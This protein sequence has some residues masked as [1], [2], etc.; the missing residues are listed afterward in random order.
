MWRLAQVAHDLQELSFVLP[1]TV[2]VRAA[3]VAGCLSEARGK[4]PGVPCDHTHGCLWLACLM[5]MLHQQLARF[6]PL[7][8]ELWRSAR[9]VTMTLVRER[10]D[11]EAQAKK[12]PPLS[13][14]V[15]LTR[16]LATQ[17]EQQVHGFG[18]ARCR[19][20]WDDVIGTDTRVSVSG[21]RQR[22]SARA[23]APAPALG[24]SGGVML[25]VQHRPSSRAEELSFANGRN[26]GSRSG[27]RAS[28]GRRRGGGH[29]GKADGGSRSPPTRV[30]RSPDGRRRGGSS[31]SNGDG[32]GR[33]T[34][35]RPSSR[36]ASTFRPSPITLQ[37]GTPANGD[38]AVLSSRALTDDEGPTTPP[39]LT[40]KKPSAA[41]DMLAVEAGTDS[42]AE[43]TTS[44]PSASDGDSGHALGWRAEDK[45]VKRNVIATHLQPGRE[46][47]LLHPFLVL[48]GTVTADV[49][50]WQ[51][52]PIMR[53]TYHAGE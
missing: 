23:T 15:A 7:L 30:S 22:R 43:G 47:F 17:P 12:W 52:S 42:G 36:D 11:T 39:P 49:L 18:L 10:A 53:V 16:A 21:M 32:H 20:H 51:L 33:D 46:E 14:A 29:G 19:D 4:A 6:D 9:L 27:R 8:L 44:A 25:T 5:S 40:P 34:S 50:D 28:R 2:L 48:Q 26:A 24:E 1:F 31:R 35:Q 38:G 13:D 45:G 37:V 41:P 3:L